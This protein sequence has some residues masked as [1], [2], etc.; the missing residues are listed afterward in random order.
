M[1]AEV[2]LNDERNAGWETALSSEAKGTEARSD[3]TPFSIH[4]SREVAI[5]A[6]ATTIHTR[7]NAENSATGLAIS[8]LKF[9]QNRFCWT[10]EVK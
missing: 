6:L 1:R 5:T 7:L 10:A 3:V 9:N 8:R 2:K 4:E